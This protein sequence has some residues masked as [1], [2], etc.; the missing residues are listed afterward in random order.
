MSES[1]IFQKDQRL[2]SILKIISQD[3]MISYN[4]LSQELAE[5]YF[6]DSKNFKLKEKYKNFT[7]K[8][9]ISKII[10]KYDE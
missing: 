3:K 2:A 10:L 1:D 5:E 8:Q 4:R 9:L 7:L 6:L